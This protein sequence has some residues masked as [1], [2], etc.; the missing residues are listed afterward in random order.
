MTRPGAPQR[1]LGDVDRYDLGP[2]AHKDCRKV[3]LAAADVEHAQRPIHASARNGNLLEQ[4]SFAQARADRR[5]PLGHAFPQA[6][7]VGTR[8]HRVARLAR[9]SGAIDWKQRERSAGDLH[10]ER[11]DRL[12][13]LIVRAVGQA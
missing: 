5:K 3:A 13:C 12:C 9:R 10:A 7:V 4:E 8:G 11:S 6:L 1:L 2:V